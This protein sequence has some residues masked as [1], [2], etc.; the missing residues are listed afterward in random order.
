MPIFELLFHMNVSI[1]RNIIVYGDPLK[2]TIVTLWFFEKL[3]STSVMHFAPYLG[4]QD[5]FHFF[6]AAQLNID[7]L[8]SGLIS[9]LLKCAGVFAHAV[10][11]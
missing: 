2:F 4:N 5:C 9:I 3:R 10:N 7:V 8:I 6:T 1:L 11:E